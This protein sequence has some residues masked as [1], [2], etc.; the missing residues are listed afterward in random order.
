VATTESKVSTLKSILVKLR[1]NKILDAAAMALLGSAPPPLGSFLVNLY[2]S[3]S[4][5][6]EDKTKQVIQILDNL[7]KFSQQQFQVLENVVLKNGEEIKSQTDS[8]SKLLVISNS[9]ANKMDEVIIIIHQL[10]EQTKSEADQIRTRITE[11]ENKLLE[12]IDKLGVSK[13]D[14]DIPA[15][16]LLFFLK[17]K[18]FL[19][20]SYEIYVQQN[21]LAH[22]LYGN[23]LLK[24]HRVTTHMKGLDYHLYELHKNN[25][26]DIEDLKNFDAIRKVTNDTEKFNWYAKELLMSNNRFMRN[27]PMLRELLV[28]YSTWQAKYQLYKDDP[29]MCLIYV[30][31]DQKAGFPKDIDNDIK[32][33]IKQLRREINLLD[34]SQ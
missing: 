28:H 20:H 21:A 6:E 33:A 15:E 17:F 4:G 13:F 24:G 9:V 19:D 18:Y 31:P 1:G 27:S 26:M 22:N 11:L 2:T 16:R 30:G 14:Y 29:N 32:M 5:S 10:S 25:M 12:E 34:N 3:A 7:Q 8:L 23:I